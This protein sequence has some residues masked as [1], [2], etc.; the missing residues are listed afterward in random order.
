MPLGYCKACDKLVAIKPGAHKPEKPLYGP[1]QRWWHVVE[2]ETPEG[3]PCVDGP[4][5]PI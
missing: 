5:K 1:P 2:H 4:K 3:K